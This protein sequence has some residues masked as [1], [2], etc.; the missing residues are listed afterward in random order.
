MW[1]LTVASRVVHTL[2][3]PVRPPEAKTELSPDGGSNQGKREVKHA[4]KTINGPIAEPVVL[5]KITLM[6]CWRVTLSDGRLRAETWRR[7]ASTQRQP[8]SRTEGTK[9]M[10]TENSSDEPKAVALEYYARLNTGGNILE[11]FAEDACCFFPKHSYARGIQ[12]VTRLVMDIVPMYKS[13][14]HDV[15]TFSFFVQ[16]NTVVVEGTTCGQ[17]T[18]AAG[19]GAWTETEG[20]RF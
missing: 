19:G 8:L 14:E 4:P 18:E 5:R 16:G 10:L 17:L 7:Q 15:A 3:G 6:V 11:L 13:L 9:D 12:E 2:A 20:G 1:V